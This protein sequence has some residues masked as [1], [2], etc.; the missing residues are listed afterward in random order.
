MSVYIR[1]NN[2]TIYSGIIFFKS[3][4]SRVPNQGS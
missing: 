1:P 3:G 4:C 2:V